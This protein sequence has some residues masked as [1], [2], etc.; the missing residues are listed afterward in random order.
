MKSSRC[1]VKILRWLMSR[2]LETRIPTLS[3]RKITRCVCSNWK[4]RYRLNHR[5]IPRRLKRC[6]NSRKRWEHVLVLDRVN[7]AVN[8]CLTTW[9]KF[10]IRPK[11]PIRLELIP[12]SVAW[13]DQENFFFPLDGMLVHPRVT[14][15]IKFVNSLWESSVLPKSRTQCPGQDSSPDHSIKETN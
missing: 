13:S 7:P 3:F 9:S 6:I 15:S 5:N 10:C 12:V 4:L 1:R 2:C 8:S 11:W 14:P